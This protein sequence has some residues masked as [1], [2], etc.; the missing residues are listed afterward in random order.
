MWLTIE[1]FLRIFFNYLSHLAF[2]QSVHVRLQLWNFLAHDAHTEHGSKIILLLYLTL[3]EQIG[4]RAAFKH[5]WF[6]SKGQVFCSWRRR[7]WLSS[8]GSKWRNWMNECTEWPNVR[9]TFTRGFCV[10][11]C[12]VAKIAL[13]FACS[14]HSWTHILR[15]RIPH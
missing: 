1:R 11:A 6:L 2:Y 14:S 10:L 8:G 9:K 7:H 4:A 12:Q 5:P 13:Q 3:T 15:I